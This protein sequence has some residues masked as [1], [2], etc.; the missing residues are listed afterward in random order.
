VTTTYKSKYRRG[1]DAAEYESYLKYSDYCKHVR[2]CARASGI[3][4]PIASGPD[5]PLMIRTVAYFKNGVHADPENIRKGVA[6]ALCYNE[7]AGSNKRKGKDKWIGGSFVP[8]RYDEDNPRV[9]VTIKRYKPSPRV[10]KE[11]VLPSKRKKRKK[12]GK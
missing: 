3:D 12:K 5:N 1:F 2:R 4:L 8:P 6:D 10:A 9:I 7:S 11:M